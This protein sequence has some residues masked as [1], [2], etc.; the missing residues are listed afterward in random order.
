MSTSL[1]IIK[2]PLVLFYLP[3]Y[4]FA[5]SVSP[6][7][8]EDSLLS[9]FILASLAILAFRAIQELLCFLRLGEPVNFTDIFLTVLLYGSL[10]YASYYFYNDY[11]ITIVVITVILSLFSYTLPN[12]NPFELS[13]VIFILSY[14]TINDYGMAQFFNFKITL[15]SLI[16][17]PMV[18]AYHRV[19]EIKKGFF[20]S[21]MALSVYLMISDNSVFIP[22]LALA[23]LP[24]LLFL[25]S[26]R[27]FLKTIRLTDYLTALLISGY[28]IYYML[29]G[30][31]LI[32]VIN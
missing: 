15:A 19:S 16:A 7:F 6:N 8:T 1:R 17:I 10:L 32:Q 29:Y 23:F 12:S 5:L 13:I 9:S 3:T 11:I 24:K 30:V 20:L 2:L 31:N 25:I 27:M 14:L 21:F 18:F 28:F 4:L 22:V 26:S